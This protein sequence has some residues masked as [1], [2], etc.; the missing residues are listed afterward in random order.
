[1]PFH[2]CMMRV[3]PM[4]PVAPR[5]RNGPVTF[6]ISVAPFDVEL[7]K[8]RNPD[9]LSIDLGEHGA[10]EWVAVIDSIE[11]IVKP[12]KRRPW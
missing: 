6:A 2:F 4:L 9:T 10:V 7:E 8:R 3:F 11:K 5:E 12:L 1:M